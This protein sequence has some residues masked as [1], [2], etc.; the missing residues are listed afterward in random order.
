[1]G[2]GVRRIARL[3]A[4]LEK[5]L[6]ILIDG[7]FRRSLSYPEA[8]EAR[9]L[10]GTSRDRSIIRIRVMEKNDPLVLK[11]NRATRRV[12]AMN[13]SGRCEHLF[14][15]TM[16]LRLME[17]SLWALEF[18]KLGLRGIAE[19]IAVLSPIALIFSAQEVVMTTVAILF[20]LHCWRERNFS[21]VGRGWFISLLALWVYAFVRTLFDHPTATGILT[22]LQWIH[23]PIYGAAL[24]HWIL[25]D[26]RSRGRLALATAGALTFYSL[27]C[28]LQYVLG[29]DVIGRPMNG[30]RLTGVFGKPGI[31]TEIAWLMLP[32]LLYFWQD[33]R[34]AL[35]LLLCSLY[36]AAV[37]LSGDRMALLIVL[38]YPVF[39]ALILRSF[40]KPLLIA[41][42]VLAALCGALLY[43]SPVTYHRQVE[44]TAE[45]IGNVKD[46]AY[47]VVFASALEIARDH[48]IFGV[49]VHNYQ[50]VCIED[51]YGPPAIGPEHYKRCQG[52][53]HNTYLLWLAEAGIIGLALYIAFVFFSVR[54]LIRSAADNWHNV[55][56]F[57]LAV[58]L[59]LRLWPLTA[60][61]SFY[62]SWSAEPMFLVLG[63]SLCF[64]CPCCECEAGTSS[65]QS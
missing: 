31:G 47:G 52:H 34:P 38:S 15:V 10:V 28:L 32:P 48:P 37:V 58:S 8:A 25:R 16:R 33:G 4:R 9:P 19:P 45:V 53:P 23:F 20:I 27:D 35:A 63:W 64:V 7:Q 40:R 12:L 59:A 17:N 29:F 1:M 57:G 42:P 61:T 65:R 39:L 50:A 62:S 3:G 2:D 43:S 55:V 14:G 54:A 46:S 22:A 11:L 41:L 18:R 21:W 26:E 60:G 13:K 24:A 44:T 36:V 56:F 6:R 30:H 5:V 49:G 51:R